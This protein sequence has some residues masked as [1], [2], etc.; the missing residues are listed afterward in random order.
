MR[1]T[2]HAQLPLTSTNSHPR[3]AE[4]VAMSAALDAN[5]FVLRGVHADLLRLREA[6]ARQGREGM[7]AEQGLRAAL[8]K[9]MFGF[10]YEQLA[11][12]LGDSLAIL[13]FC[14]ISPS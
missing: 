11:F 4:L 1:Q 8:I 14:R 13:G 2:Y 7:T 9:Q 6:S 3:A 5:A 12:H 10:S